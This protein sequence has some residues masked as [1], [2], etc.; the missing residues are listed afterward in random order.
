MPDRRHE[1]RPPRQ[2][3]EAFDLRHM[4]VLETKRVQLEGRPAGAVMRLD[5]R[6]AAAGITTDRAYRDRVVGRNEPYLDERAQQADSASRVAAGIADLARYRDLP[7]LI[8]R[9]FRKAVRPF[10]IDPVRAARVEQFRRVVA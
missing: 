6:S 5:H 4:L 1:D 3:R 7:G 10:R 9:H 2:P 8:G